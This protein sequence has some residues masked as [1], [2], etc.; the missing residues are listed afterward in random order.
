[1]VKLVVDSFGKVSILECLLLASGVEYELEILDEEMGLITPFLVV[2][3]VPLDLD[4]SYKWLK[5]RS[6]A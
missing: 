5:E 6:E 2:D 4:R 1:M 3:G